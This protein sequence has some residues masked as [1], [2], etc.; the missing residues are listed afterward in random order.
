MNEVLILSCT[1]EQENYFIKLIKVLFPKADIVISRA[2]IDDCV[3]MPGGTP[4]RVRS[5][6][7][8]ATVSLTIL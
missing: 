1:A 4:L 5:D 2:N 3:E 7:G 6:H 8:E